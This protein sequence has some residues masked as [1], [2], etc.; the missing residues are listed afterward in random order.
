M[1]SYIILISF[2]KFVFDVFHYILWILFYYMSCE[3]CIKIRFKKQGSA[4]H[5]WL[6][7]IGSGYFIELKK[8]II[9]FDKT[10]RCSVW[11][12]EYTIKIYFFKLCFYYVYS[13]ACENK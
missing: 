11:Y 10:S 3:N 9:S 5:V 13:Q 1:Y 4:L 2:K 7:T 12:T 6:N 8:K